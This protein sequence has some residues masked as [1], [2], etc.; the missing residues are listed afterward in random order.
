MNPRERSLRRLAALTS[1]LVAALAALLVCVPLQVLLP[2]IAG[3]DFLLFRYYGELIA[4][5]LVGAVIPL[6]VCF[7]LI[8]TVLLRGAKRRGGGAFEE[9]RFWLS[10]LAIALVSTAVFTAASA[11]FGGLNLPVSWSIALIPGGAVVGVAF[12]L[13]RRKDEK[14]LAGFAECYVLGT[15]ATLLSDLVRTL[16]GL[17]R[18]PVLAWGG[19]GTHDLVFWFGIYTGISF[20]AFSLLH[21]RLLGLWPWV[22]KTRVGADEGAPGFSPVVGSPERVEIRSGPGDDQ[23]TTALS[24]N[25]V[26]KPVNAERKTNTEG[27]PHAR[28]GPPLGFE[29]RTRQIR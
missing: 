5:D 18:A 24:A 25:L 14:L 3:P 16:S 2:R 21:P 20:L 17:V 12:G 22:G 8:L 29:S 19:D 28:N 23:R 15:L 26:K 7:T 27:I 6:L 4:I 11:E 13:T 1:G 9:S 10:V